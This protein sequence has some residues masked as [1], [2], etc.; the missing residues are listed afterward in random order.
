MMISNAEVGIDED[1]INELVQLSHSAAQGP[2]DYMMCC[3][4][5]AFSRYYP[6]K[7]SP[8]LRPMPLLAVVGWLT[9][10]ACTTAGG[11]SLSHKH[12]LH[13]LWMCLRY[14]KLLSQPCMQ[15]SVQVDQTPGMV[16]M[17]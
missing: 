7:H 5:T 9:M 1:D 17:A 2:L 11:S 16:I 4:C 15:N 6:D 3:F 8:N 14:N 13:V 10:K 12:P